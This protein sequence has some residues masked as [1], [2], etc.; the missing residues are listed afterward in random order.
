[1]S[2]N[3]DIIKCD[4]KDEL[5]YDMEGGDVIAEGGY[6]CVLNPSLSCKGT[7]TTNEKYITKI[8]VLNETSEREIEFSRM[9]R[10]IPR[11]SKHFA[12]IHSTCEHK[13][14]IVK[15]ISNKYNCSFLSEHPNEKF[16]I[17]KIKYIKG[18]MFKTHIYNQM[19]SA[20]IFYYI[21]HSYVY[22]LF[23]IYIL[24]KYGII[25]YDLKG[26]NIMYDTTHKKPIIIDF[27]LSIKKDDIK[28]DFKNADYTNR[29]KH[30]FYT[31][32]PDYS[33]W[34]LDIHY[35]SFI[36]N[37]PDQNVKNYIES[38][39]DTY[40][41]NNKAIKHASNDFV[42]KYKELSMKQLH[43][44][45]KMGV[46]K[47]VEYLYKYCNTWDN[48]SIS[49]MFLRMVDLFDLKEHRFLV[50]LK[51][52]LR[53]NI[54]PDPEKRISIKKTHDYII[55]Y[56]KTNT[57]NVDIFQPIIDNIETNKKSIKDN[58][59]KQINR[60]KAL[61]QKMSLFKK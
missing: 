37:N 4:T 31:Y 52:L 38:M 9:V 14:S 26:E 49:I 20:D 33:L 11:Y 48:Y 39:V 25:H 57:Q 1:M 28:P 10:K 2:D 18:D 7:E 54:H 5:T 46:K 56:L 21:I 19:E 47:S 42:E 51:M 55:S 60:D 15:M 6:G 16:A 58:L 44:Y 27:G 50:F 8:Q 53:N 29:L 35:L 12:P 59:N 13:P 22:L 32:A 17:S 3:I 40:I 61:S 24:D 34:C 43:K 41:E 36:I 23:S 45:E 30:N